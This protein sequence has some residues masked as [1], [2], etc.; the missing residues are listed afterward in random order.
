[1]YIN[2]IRLSIGRYWYFLSQFCCPTKIISDEWRPLV[3]KR[4]KNAA[5]EIGSLICIDVFLLPVSDCD[6][7]IICCRYWRYYKCLASEYWLQERFPFV[8]LMEKRLSGLV[9]RIWSFRQNQCRIICWLISLWARKTEK[10]NYV[11]I[12]WFLQTG[13]I[14]KHLSSR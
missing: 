2:T 8:S 5:S 6:N 7:L 13:N 1:M 3:T 14:R 11:Q 9:N 4:K 12:D 10:H